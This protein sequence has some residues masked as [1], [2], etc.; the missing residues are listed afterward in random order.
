[1][2]ITD[3]IYIAGHRGLVGSAILRQLQLKGFLNLITRSSDELD[4]TNQREVKKFFKQQ[5]PSYVIVAAA[6]VGGIHANNIYPAE[7]IYQNIMI[8]ANIIHSSYEN[9]VSRLLFLGSTC[10]YP[11][12]VKQPMQEDAL[13]TGRLEKTNEP[14]ALAKI[15]GIKLCESYNR[16]YGTDF[17]S[18]MPTNLYGENDNFHLEN[19][20]VI[21]ALLRKIYL[22]KCLEEE[23]WESIKYDLDKNPIDGIDNKSS[24]NEVLAAL[25]G[26]GIHF[27]LITMSSSVN[28]WG[29]GN[30]KRE[31]LYVDDMALASIFILE[32]NEKTYQENT[33][34]MLSHINI[35]TGLDIKISDLAQK[36]K[37]IVGF[38]GV[39]YFDT[40]KLDGPSRKLTDVSKISYMGWSSEINLEEGLRK[41][42]DWYSN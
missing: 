28:I 16:Q 32:L 23:N 22:A 17:R 21:P 33:Q 35:G 37:E 4:L 1:L 10:I 5:K 27:D 24:Q 26:Y 6:R 25:R 31:F 40:S 18:I 19:S 30:V 41:T 15:A 13:L 7:F 11:K 42:Y 9:G 38:K 2:K 12:E 29:S 36:I 39:L 20:H 8:E 3:K 14:Y 34:P